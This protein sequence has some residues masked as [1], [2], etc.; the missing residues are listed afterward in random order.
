M[1]EIG[2]LWL[3]PSCPGEEKGA[4]ANVIYLDWNASGLVDSHLLKNKFVLIL[5][6]GFILSSV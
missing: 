6:F 1:G 2:E 5:N 4:E 3:E